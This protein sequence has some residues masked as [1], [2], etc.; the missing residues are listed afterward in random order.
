MA[1][2]QKRI[3]FISPVP[4]SPATQGNRVVT[5]QLVDGLIERGYAVDVVFQGG[6]NSFYNEKANFLTVHQTTPPRPRRGE[7]FLI[8]IRNILGFKLYSFFVCVSPK[9]FFSR[10]SAVKVVELLAHRRYEAVICNHLYSIPIIES[11]R[12]ACPQVPKVIVITLDSLSRLPW[13]GFKLGIR[14]GRRAI[15]KEVESQQLNRADLVVAITDYERDYFLKIGVK[16][17]IMVSAGLVA[18]ESVN[19]GIIKGEESNVLYFSASDNPLNLDGFLWFWKECWPRIKEVCPEASLTIAGALGYKLKEVCDGYPD[20]H[21]LGTATKLV[22]EFWLAHAKVVINPVRYGTGLKIKSQEAVLQ[23]RPLVTTSSG[24]EGLSSFA[25]YGLIAVA[26]STASFAAACERFLLT[27]VDH[28]RRQ[29]Q[30]A[31]SSEKFSKVRVL[32]FLNTI[33]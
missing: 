25:T 16:T 31:S 18:N 3:L 32:D 1:V 21:I 8:F 26:D 15:T 13:I 5:R 6:G 2:E 27:P 20:V 30:I 7:G 29:E 33:R 23:G 14:L 28:S 11:A 17:R 4:C 22:H 19:V 12:R 10:D 9:S 24:V